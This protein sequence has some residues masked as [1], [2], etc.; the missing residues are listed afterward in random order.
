MRRVA[1]TVC[2]RASIWLARANL[3]PENSSSA[4]TLGGDNLGLDNG[5]VPLFLCR[6]KSEL[7][8]LPTAEEEG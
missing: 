5:H 8:S 4:L 3:C 2:G 1:E 6:S 7:L